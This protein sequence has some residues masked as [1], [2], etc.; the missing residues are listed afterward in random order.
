MR[1][2][3]V[4]FFDPSKALPPVGLSVL[5]Q[6]SDKNGN[7]RVGIGHIDKFVDEGRNPLWKATNQCT[8]PNYW[9]Y[10]PEV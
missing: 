9:A 4:D 1:R 10:I 2:K 7:T 3:L 5:L 6:E 8:N